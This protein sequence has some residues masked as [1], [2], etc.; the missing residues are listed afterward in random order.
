[1]EDKDLFILWHLLVSPKW[2]T[3]DLCLVHVYYKGVSLLI[4][5][6]VKLSHHYIEKSM[7]K[8]TFEYA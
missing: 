7:K 8:N 1:M 3:V 2:L 5:P 4:I 6:V